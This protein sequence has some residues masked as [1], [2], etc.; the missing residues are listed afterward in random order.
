VKGNRVVR[1]QEAKQYLQ[2]K[3]QGFREELQKLWHHPNGPDRRESKRRMPGSDDLRAAVKSPEE[4]VGFCDKR[5]YQSQLIAKSA[6]R[7]PEMKREKGRG[8]DTDE[9]I[10]EPGSSRRTRH[11]FLRRTGVLS[12]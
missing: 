12:P 2:M 9:V 3:A 4:S 8:E 10:S 1:I 5:V 11:G 6:G 7:S